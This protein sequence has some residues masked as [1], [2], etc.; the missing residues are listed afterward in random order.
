MI[1][2][3]LLTKTT[4]SK[5]VQPLRNVQQIDNNEKILYRNLRLSNE[6]G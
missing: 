1:V 2:F 4:L 6:C 3:F 5:L